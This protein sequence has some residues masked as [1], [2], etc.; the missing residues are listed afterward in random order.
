MHSRFRRLAT[1]L[2]LSLAVGCGGADT[3]VRETPLTTEPPTTATVTN[4]VEAPQKPRKYVVAKVVDGDTIDL[5]GGRRVRLV[6]IDTPEV[7]EGECYAVEALK[8]LEALIPPGTTITLE[9]DPLLDKVDRYG[10]LLRYVRNGR[11]N[12]NTALVRRGAASVW[13]FRGD[14]GRYAASLLRAAR[15]ARAARRGLWRACPG[16]RFDPY[17]AVETKKRRKRGE[18]SACAPGYS[19]C[20]PVT[21]DIDCGDIADSKKPVRV[22]GEDRYRLDSDGD[23]Y[24]CDGG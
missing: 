24:G 14:R 5:A 20:L 3:E 16:T 2:V 11:L 6:Q 22:T 4:R 17:E 8:A 12:V 10:R 7:S 18:R 13:F 1:L 15:Q 23:G 19:P 9:A 21:G